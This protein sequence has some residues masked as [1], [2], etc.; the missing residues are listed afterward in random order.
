MVGQCSK[1]E[2][3]SLKYYT[4]ERGRFYS[5]VGLVKKKKFHKKNVGITGI[6]RWMDL[7]LNFSYCVSSTAKFTKKILVHSWFNLLGQLIHKA[8]HSTVLAG[9]DH[10]FHTECPSVRPSQSLKI[11]RQSLRAAGTVG[12]PSGSLMTPVLYL[13]IFKS[14]SLS[15]FWTNLLM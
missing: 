8:D 14:V 1:S 9:S 10:Y 2:T 4:E 11:K 3:C 5:F 6:S 12:W 15:N 13:I 7:Q